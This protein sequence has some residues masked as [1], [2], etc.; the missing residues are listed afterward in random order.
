M[1]RCFDFERK[2][3]MMV[4]LHVIVGILLLMIA[5]TDHKTM[6]IPDAYSLAL[7]VCGILAI[8][9]QPEITIQ[10]RLIGCFCVSLPMYLM[11]ILIPGSFGGGDVKLTFAMGFYLGWKQMYTGTFLA[12]LIGGIEAVYLLASGKAKAGEGAH[13]AFGPALCAGFLLAMVWG[14][15]LTSWYLGLFF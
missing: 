11:I 8:V 13:M 6:M 5:W 10:E 1:L 12:L 9:L 15:Q 2:N 14:Q 7:I 4:W 3:E